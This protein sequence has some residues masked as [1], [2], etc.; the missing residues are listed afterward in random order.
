[1]ADQQQCDHHNETHCFN[2]AE[3]EGK[4]DGAL[5]RPRLSDMV[6]ESLTSHPGGLLH[7]VESVDKQLIVFV[8]K[9]MTFLLMS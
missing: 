9:K 8:E 3:P 4:D 7:L 2:Q 5:S 6:T 1:M